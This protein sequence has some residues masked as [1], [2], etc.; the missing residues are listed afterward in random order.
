M[1]NYNCISNVNDYLFS[2]IDIDVKTKLKKL[3]TYQGDMSIRAAGAASPR[4]FEKN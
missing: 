1:T 3:Y 4:T 2:N